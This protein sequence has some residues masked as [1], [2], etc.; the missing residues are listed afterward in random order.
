[1]SNSEA[2]EYRQLSDEAID[3]LSREQDPE[4]RDYWGR[5]A[6][7]YSRLVDLIEMRQGLGQ[8]L[9][10]TLRRARAINAASDLRTIEIADQ[11]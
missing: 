6:L 11:K 1:M 10:T 8:N 5:L 2:A 7:E 9:S 3:R 4:A